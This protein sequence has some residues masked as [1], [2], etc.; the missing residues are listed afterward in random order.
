MTNIK[1]ER[2]EFFLARSQANEAVHNRIRNEIIFR[3]RNTLEVD[4]CP[5]A[6]MHFTIK[7]PI[8]GQAFAEMTIIGILFLT[9]SQ[10]LGSEQVKANSTD[11]RGYRY[12]STH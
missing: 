3:N 2:A 5:P 1:A 10:G 12:F 11:I 7:W 8:G 6:G 9:Q 4:S